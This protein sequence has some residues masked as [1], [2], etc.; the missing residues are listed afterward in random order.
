MK[1]GI[2]T[3]GHWWTVLKPFEDR[4]AVIVDSKELGPYQQVAEPVFSQDGTEWAVLGLNNLRWQITTSRET[5]TR[6]A[7]IKAVYFPPNLSEVWWVETVAPQWTLTNGT[8]S[9]GSTYPIDQVKFHPSGIVAAWVEQLPDVQAL[10]R[11]GSEV[12]RADQIS[13]GGVWQTGECVYAARFGNLWTVY[14]GEKELASNL[15]S[16]SALRVN[17]EGTTVSWASVRGGAPSRVN[18]Y[19]DEYREPWESPP[20]DGMPT[21]VV[22]SPTEKL[23]A[24][25][26]VING[27]RKVGFNGATFPQGAS[28]GKPVF[29]HDGATM[30]YTSRDDDNYVYVNGKRTRV[31]TQVPLSTTLVISPSGETCCWASSTSI[32]VVDLEYG[33]LQLGKM[34]DEVS[35]PIYDVDARQFKA[36][37]IV[38]GRLYMLTCSAR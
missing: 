21:N 18:L 8:R 24:Y 11:N 30:A 23:V 37:G 29:S 28:A 5:I 7:V 27:I 1:Y 15:T 26:G 4:Y 17:R 12:T 14:L 33:G 34:C 13:L 35:E 38:A 22:M 20:V 32:V 2:D 16:V 31:D 36:L 10:R 6:E 9:F 25:H 19:N 3:T